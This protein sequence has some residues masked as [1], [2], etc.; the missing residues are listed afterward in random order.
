MAAVSPSLI[1]LDLQD[2]YK[3]FEAMF[4]PQ[5]FCRFTNKTQCLQQVSS[6]TNIRLLH[7]FIPKSEHGEIGTGIIFLNTIFYLYCID[8]ASENE[9]IQRYPQRLFVKVI[10]A[11]SLLT[12]LQQA[13]LIHYIEQAERRKHEPDEHNDALQGAIDQSLALAKELE[14]HKLEKIGVQPDDR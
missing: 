12:S 2:E 5:L 8:Q 3:R 11:G 14:K 13:A 7:F 9:M 4:D 6:H 10:S 1:L